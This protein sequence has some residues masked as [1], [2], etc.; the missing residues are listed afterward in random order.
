[1]TDLKEKLPFSKHKRKKKE[2]MLRIEQLQKLLEETGGDVDPETV[3]S[4][5]MPHRRRKL[6]ADAIFHPGGHLQLFVYAIHTFDL[7]GDIF[8][9]TIRK[10]TNY[11]K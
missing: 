7:P 5:Y 8:V 9:I 11:S 10:I 1:M 6:F 4:L 3:V 2:E